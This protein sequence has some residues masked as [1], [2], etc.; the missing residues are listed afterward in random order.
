MEKTVR[1]IPDISMDAVQ[2][3]TEIDEFTE[4]FD[5]Y[6]YRDQVS[7]KEANIAEIAGNIE[8]G[9]TDYLKEYLSDIIAE[10]E[11]ESDVTQ[12]REL[13]IKLN[14]YKPLA[15]VEELEEA[16]FN[17][18]D[19]VINNTKSPDEKLEE[20][21]QKHDSNKVKAGRES[22]REK[23]KEKKQTVQQGDK[24]IKSKTVTRMRTSLQEP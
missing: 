11:V 21:K 1:S 14:E 5:P 9:D 19:N 16:N 3:A 17:M 18:I 10:S 12:A 13:Q 6:E 22:L 23:L 24:E 2:L 7:D 15:K 4:N 8:N 20:E